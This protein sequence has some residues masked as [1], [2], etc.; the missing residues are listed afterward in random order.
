M[1]F[2]RNWLS[3]PIVLGVIGLVCSPIWLPKE[4]A[5]WYLAAAANAFRLDDRAQGERLLARAL[6]WD[7]RLDKDG[8][9]WIAQIAKSQSPDE[10]L[11]L[12][13]KATRV[14]PQ[15]GRQGPMLA[16]MFVEEYDFQRAV[17]ALKLGFP[18]GQPI[19]PVERNDLAYYRALAGIELDAALADINRA[20]EEVGREP[21]FLDTKAWVLHSMRRNLEALPIIREAVELMDASV[22]QLPENPPANEANESTNSDVVDEGPLWENLGDIRQQIAAAKRRLAPRGMWN[23][24]V[25]RFH[26]L[27]I[28]EA[29]RQAEDARRERAWLVKHGVP[30]VDELF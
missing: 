1:R 29:L 25:L 17:R 6:T 9:Y 21:T 13:E 7:T 3:L 23:L 28:L 30:I 22:A 26:H 12:L 19:H 27:K 11:D 15:R 20:I 14:N 16:R 5:R 18:N 8:D 2:R 24:A 10:Q 4:I